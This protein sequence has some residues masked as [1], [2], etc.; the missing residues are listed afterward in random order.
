M[1]QVSSNY[2]FLASPDVCSVFT[3]SV[4]LQET[5]EIVVK[6]IFE[7]NPQL[8]VTKRELKQPFNLATSGTHFIFNSTFYDQVDGVSVGSPLGSVLDNLL[9]GDHKKKLVA[10]I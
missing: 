10:R 1:Q 4:P 9:M 7:H 6:L 3:I 8:K 2:V 5:I